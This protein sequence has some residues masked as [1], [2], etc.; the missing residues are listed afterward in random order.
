[1]EQVVTLIR[2]KIDV[3]DDCYEAWW[4]RETGENLGTGSRNKYGGGDKYRDKYRDK[5]G[6][7]Q[8]G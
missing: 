3:N 5:Y 7:R 8:E 4:N 2:V 1:V 6:L